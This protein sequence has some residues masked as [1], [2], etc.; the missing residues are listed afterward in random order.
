MIIFS[1]PK[2]F[3]GHIGLIQHNAIESWLRHIPARNILLLGSEDGVRET[4]KRYRLTHLPSLKTNTEGTPVLSDIFRRAQTVKSDLY[5]YVNT[6]IILLNS[7][8]L[9]ASKVRR[10][11]KSF[12]AVGQ[13]Y[14]MDIKGKADFEKIQAAVTG[15]AVRRK[16]SA[17]MDY[18]LF[19]GGVY[20]DVPPFALGKTF[21]DKW[22]VWS[23][24][25]R[26]I[27]VVDMTGE[28]A[29]VHQTH[30]YG[31]RKTMNRG[32][33]WAGKEALENLRLAGGWSKSATAAD[34]TYR[35]EGG[36]LHRQRNA[37]R[38]TVRKLLD[39]LPWMWLCVL[40]MRLLRER[41]SVVHK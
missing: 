19:T 41:L 17:W 18:F 22:L 37:R 29:A 38:R 3:T 40:R 15:G 5:L 30:S 32:T 36:T 13:R 4:V 12:V 28:L 2:A 33:V 35:L 7:P 1:V 8:L 9:P 21:W 31:M 6:D 23:A 26:H 16:S 20:G 25:N 39:R 14:E 10:Q 27:P 24:L 34:A 11:L